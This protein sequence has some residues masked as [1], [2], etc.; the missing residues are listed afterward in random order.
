MSRSRVS[1]GCSSYGAGDGGSDGEDGGG[2]G[3]NELGLALSSSLDSLDTL[4]VL[5]LLSVSGLARCVADS[6]II[7]ILTS[8]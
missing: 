5:G 1:T 7:L 3:G 8:A 6:G 2:D 4:L